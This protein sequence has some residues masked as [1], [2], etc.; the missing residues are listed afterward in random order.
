MAARL[1]PMMS[2]GNNGNTKQVGAKGMKCRS[3]LGYEM[4]GLNAVF[5]GEC[6]RP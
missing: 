5:I 4:T 6:N 2:A 1:S 3:I